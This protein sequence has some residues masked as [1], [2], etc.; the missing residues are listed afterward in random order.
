MISLQADHYFAIGHHHH[1]GGKPCQDYAQSGVF[2][3]PYGKMVFGVISDGC[4]SGG[5]T[6]VGARIVAISTSIIL[7]QHYNLSPFGEC[8]ENQSMVD[9]I[10]VLQIYKIKEAISFLR[11]TERDAL[12]TSGYIITKGY[13]GYVHLDGDGVVFLRGKDKEEIMVKISWDKEMPYYPIYRYSEEEFIKAHG[14]DRHLAAVTEEWWQ[15]TGT[16]AWKLLQEKRVSIHN[17]MKGFTFWFNLL[18]IEFDCI[19]VFS[20]GVSQVENIDW[21]EAVTQL[22]AFKTTAGEFVKRRAMRFISESKNV[23]KGPLDDISCAV[24]LIKNEEE[25]RR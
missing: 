14:G 12:A 6:D 25:V 11:I 22:V 23:G 2:E 9:F 18:E 15:R 1:R 10:S 17:G 7:Q 13:G 3:T 20:D 16:G 24:V 4:S 21:K 5:N 8:I 19:A